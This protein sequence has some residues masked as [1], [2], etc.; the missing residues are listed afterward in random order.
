[1]KSK[2][3]KS[4][5]Y[6]FTKK[7]LFRKYISIISISIGLSIVLISA[8]IVS[9]SQQS[10][11]DNSKAG[12]LIISNPCITI[13]STSFT[14]SFINTTLLPVTEKLST[15]NLLSSTFQNNVNKTVTTKNNLR[16]APNYDSNTLNSA[17][18]RKYNL[19]KAMRTNPQLALDSINTS[20]LYVTTVNNCVEK[21]VTLEGNIEKIHIDD[22]K[23]KKCLWR[24]I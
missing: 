11:I 23:K 6:F 13:P 10:I 21:Q 5:Y 3:V 9:N 20:K 4:T 8:V 12:T 18:I 19:V 7:I 15:L 17:N 14:P 2:F 16:L 24:L 1:M 22:F